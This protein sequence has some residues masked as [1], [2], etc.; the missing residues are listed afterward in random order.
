MTN[1]EEKME[2]YDDGAFSVF[3]TSY[4]MYSSRDKNGVGLCCGLVKE[5]VVFW[6]REHLNGFANS[7]V[8]VTNTKVGDVVKL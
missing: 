4:G 1:Q 3:Y 2:V 7:A 8:T 5:D 6:S